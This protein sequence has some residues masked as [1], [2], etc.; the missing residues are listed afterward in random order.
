MRYLITILFIFLFT[1]QS[2]G[3]NNSLQTAAGVSMSNIAGDGRYTYFISHFLNLSYY[4]QIN[5]SLSFGLGAE[6]SLKGGDYSYGTLLDT[7]TYIYYKGNLRLHY[8]IIPVSARV[9][10]RNFILASNIYSGI[11]L[12]ATGQSLSSMYINNQ[13]VVHAIADSKLIKEAYNKPLL[14]FGVGIGYYFNKS[15]IELSYSRDIISIDNLNDY[16]FLNTDF[17]LAYY[18]TIA[19]L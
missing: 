2:I 18:I 19:E 6:Y 5:N 13:S 14:G 3:Q 11:K 15:M 10:W 9:Y 1:G 8:L 12:Y 7:S 16:K 17:K 4:R